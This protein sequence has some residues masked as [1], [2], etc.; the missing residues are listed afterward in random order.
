MQLNFTEIEARPVAGLIGAEILGVNLSRP[1]TERA[2][3]EIRQALLK[4]KVIFFRGQALGHAEHVALTG[5]FGE[6]TRA[7]P[8]APA[9]AEFPQILEVK[10]RPETPGAQRR[11][12]AEQ[13]WHT[14][15]TAAINPPA[16]AILRAVRVPAHGGDTMWTNLVAAYE[17][18]SAPLRTLA[19]GLTAEHRFNARGVARDANSAYHQRIAAD[20]MVSNHPVVRVHPESGERALFVNPVFTSHIRELS[21]RESERLL[22]LFF[23]HIANPAFAVR[24]RWSPGDVAFWDNR[25]TAHLAPQDLVR[26]DGER[27]LYRT[28][29]TGDVPV[30]PSG[31]RSEPVQ[32]RPFGGSP[33]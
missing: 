13:L 9:H 11:Y 12:S 18:L 33:P 16:A 22:D 6:V 4:W 10:W 25:A 24:F 1:L 30:G 5:R 3:S 27:T 19:D 8:Y 17:A 14:D 32:G 28:T 31:F 15:M 20:P 29:L 7:H 23:E 2:V 26:F 21:P